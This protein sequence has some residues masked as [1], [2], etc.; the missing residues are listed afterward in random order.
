MFPRCYIG[1]RGGEEGKGGIGEDVKEKR[2]VV[3]LKANDSS[4]QSVIFTSFSDSS[5]SNIAQRVTSDLARK[6]DKIQLRF[7]LSKVSNFISGLV[8]IFVS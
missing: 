8:S 3:L 2:D 5:M 6:R 1:T 4:L 7:T